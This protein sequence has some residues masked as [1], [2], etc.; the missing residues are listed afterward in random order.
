MLAE[1]VDRVKASLV[2]KID[3]IYY[4]TDS[5]IALAWIQR[6]SV[7]LKTFVA[8]R[9]A[10]IQEL[11]NINSWNHVPGVLNPADHIS[12]DLLPKDLL[13]CSSWFEGPDF[14]KYESDIWPICREK[15][16]QV[17]EE[18]C[19]VKTCLHV[20]PSLSDNMNIIDDINHRNSIITLKHVV[21][22]VIRFIR[23]CKLTHCDRIRTNY[24]NVDEINKAEI[25][26]LKHI[27]KKE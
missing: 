10:D 9:V 8:N 24:L 16:T 7:S 25:C 19:E 23:N 26:I 27:Q 18:L 6:P 5:R 13:E 4:W 22:T 12:R 20:T 11:S 1:L 17:E 14:L 21:A 15:Y 2:Y 3:N